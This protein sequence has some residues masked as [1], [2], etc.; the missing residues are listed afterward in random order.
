[1]YHTVSG[2]LSNGCDSV[3]IL[4]L[5]INATQST[6]TLTTCD[7]LTW[8]DG[9]TYTVSNNTAS[10]TYTN[11]LGCDSTIFLDLIVDYSSTAT[12][13][14]VFCGSSYTWIDGN[15]YTAANTTATHTLTNTIGCDSIVTLNLTINPIYSLTETYTECDSFTWSDGITYTTSNNTA[16]QNLT[17]MSGCDSVVTL[18]LTIENSYAVTDNQTVC[19]SSFTWIDG[20]TYT[21]SNSTATHTFTTVGG[22][23]SV[24]SLNLTLTH[25]DTSVTR[26]TLQLTANQTGASYQWLDCSNNYTAIAGETNRELLITQSGDYAVEITSNGCVDTS[27]CFAFVNVGVNEVVVNQDITVYPNPTFNYVT[28]DL[29]NV[30]TSKSEI[31][32]IDLSGKT[33]FKESVTKT[34]SPWTKQ[35]DLSSFAPGS[36][37]VKVIIDGEEHSFAVSKL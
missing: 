30:T 6:Q 26:G 18:D 24:I 17:S 37:F 23:D 4:D 25:I 27:S 16:V 31:L 33:I 11:V 15:S 19:A 14:I 35:I 5:T 22:C 20:I 1:V 21:A 8:I 12:D 13:T 34:N 29:Q 2:V 10:V 9:V 7:S 36:Y 3:Y 28:I 32:V